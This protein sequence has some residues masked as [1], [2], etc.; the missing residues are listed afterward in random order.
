MAY[1][2]V[3]IW[4]IFFKYLVFCVLKIIL[5]K[6]HGFFFFFKKIHVKLCIAGLQFTVT[7]APKSMK[8]I[9]TGLYYF[10][11][12][13]G[14]LMGTAIL[15]TLA[16]SKTW[17]YKYNFG[18]INCRYSCPVDPSNRST[19]KVISTGDCHLDYYFYMLAG[20]DLVA[21]FLFLIVARVFQLSADQ[22]ALTVKTKDGPVEKG[23]QHIQRQSLGAN[24]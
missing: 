17:F 8:A 14:S 6:S 3:Y 23:G 16:S 1:E 4:N 19:L 15:T 7:L 2:P 5:L 13:I 18:N 20:I 12:G 24:N 9:I 10:F 21:I 22:L 11:S